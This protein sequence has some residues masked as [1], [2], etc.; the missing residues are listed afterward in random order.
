MKRDNRRGPEL[1][2]ALPSPPALH[3]T[4]LATLENRP[5]IAVL[6]TRSRDAF[7]KGHLAGSLLTE[8][9]YQ[10]CS[11]AGSYVAEGIPVYLIVHERRLDEAVR[12]LI[13]VG[14]DRIAGY[15]TPD[16]IADYERQGGTL[17]RTA[18]IDMRQMEDERTAGRAHVLDV[19]GA[20]EFEAGHVP[21]AIHVPHTRIG[22]SLDTV[23]TDKPLLVYCNSGARAAAAAAMLERLGLTA[24]DVNDNFANYRHA[25]PV[26]SHG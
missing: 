15:I 13:R 11:I 9:D 20:T 7:F 18:T 5:D 2:P 12:A 3:A 4:D 1:L 23:P 24:I 22:V 14:L 26:T 8:L 10:F 16:T 21:G 25:D 17:R 19:R 6:D